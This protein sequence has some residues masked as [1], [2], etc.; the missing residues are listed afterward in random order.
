MIGDNNP[1]A[2]EAYALHI[3]ELFALVNDTTA[4][5]TVADDTQEAALDAL[6]ND[7]RKAGRDA[8][9]ERAAEK[10]PHDDAAKA[11]QEKWL[12]LI[13]R[14]DIGVEAIK[15]L[16]TPYR[17]AKRAAAE[18]AARKLREEAQARQKAAQAAFQSDDLQARFDAEQDLKAAKKLTA[19]ANKTERAPTGLR[20]R[21]VA[22]LS[23]SATALKY[24][25]ESQPELLKA[26]LLEQAQRET[27]AGARIIPGFTIT[28]ERKAA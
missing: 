18:Q 22:E 14:C 7:L 21:W 27:N 9:A 15:A 19:V 25:R 23:D 2:H 3:E 13:K 26:W 6:M 11:V 20:T 10:K 12:P 24:Y 17:A 1:P 5:A 16:L 4:G 28:E 8:N